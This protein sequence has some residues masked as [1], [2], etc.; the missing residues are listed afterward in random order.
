MG[1]QGGASSFVGRFLS[2]IHSGKVGASPGREGQQ[3]IE[4]V[5]LKSRA[6]DTGQG[7]GSAPQSQQVRG[8][9]SHT[10]DQ[11]G[12]RAIRGRERARKDEDSLW[13]MVSCYL[14]WASVKVSE[15][16]D[17]NCK[18]PFCKIL[19]PL[20][21]TGLP[22]RSSPQSILEFLFLF[23]SLVNWKW[24]FSQSCLKSMWRRYVILPPTQLGNYPSLLKERYWFSASALVILHCGQG[25]VLGITG[26]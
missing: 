16:T 13:G 25:S 17:S 6:V 19:T 3:A 18:Q 7:Q 26:A 2:Q 8:G 4:T 11:E 1:C 15:Q 23:C 21:C 5:G 9:Q 20:T 10:G 22:Q 24:S 12:C 14:L